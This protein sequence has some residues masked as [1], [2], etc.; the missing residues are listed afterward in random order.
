M[1]KPSELLI[2]AECDEVYPV[3]RR[4]CP[5]CTSAQAVPLT[6]LTNGQSVSLPVYKVRLV[7]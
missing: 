5:S 3:K 7:A 2:C 4:R 6:V 1:S